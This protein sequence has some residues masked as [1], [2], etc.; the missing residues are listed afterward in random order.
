MCRRV[1]REKRIVLFEICFACRPNVAY[2]CI[3]WSASV[4]GRANDLQVQ[5]RRWQHLRWI[6]D[7]P[8]ERLRST[9][10]FIQLQVVGGVAV[11]DTDLNVKALHILLLRVRLDD[12]RCVTASSRQLLL[13]IALERRQSQ[14]TIA[15]ERVGAV[16]PNQ[17]RLNAAGIARVVL[18]QV[19]GLLPMTVAS[20]RVRLASG[21]GRVECAV[22][23]IVEVLQASEATR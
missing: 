15:V 9:I 23:G 8:Q 18:V 14:G 3:L 20:E 13:S 21:R 16:L 19:Q 17:L 10:E 6:V 22:S 2:V 1:E 4:G 12:V 5:L 7:L 11:V